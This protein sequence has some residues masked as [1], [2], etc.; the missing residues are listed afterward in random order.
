M[1]VVG[2]ITA[3]VLAGPAPAADP[4]PGPGSGSR[5]VE[6]VR[7]KPLTVKLVGFKPGLKLTV[8]TVP[9]RAERTVVTEA[10]GTTVVRLGVDGTS[11][12]R[13]VTSV[14][15]WSRTSTRI[16]SVRLPIPECASAQ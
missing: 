14:T 16:A 9:L 2:V 8:K 10:D 12:T 5:K 11:C 6:I 1:L 4:T 3:T 15:V 7:L 13:R